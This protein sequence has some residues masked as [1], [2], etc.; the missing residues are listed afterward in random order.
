MCVT[1][2]RRAERLRFDFLWTN[3]PKPKR[4]RSAA[5][6]SSLLR[7]SGCLASRFASESP[8]E[9]R[10]SSFYTMNILRRFFSSLCRRLRL[11]S[12][13]IYLISLMLLFSSLSSC[14]CCVIFSFQFLF[15]KSSCWVVLFRY[16]TK[17]FFS[18]SWEIFLWFLGIDKAKTL[19]SMFQLFSR[20]RNERF[21]LCDGSLEERND[22]HEGGWKEKIK[23]N[24]LVRPSQ[25]LP[26][27]SYFRC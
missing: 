16:S 13:F 9:K 5:Q 21:D 26:N 24:H 19:F 3:H 22:W 25:Y 14:C 10:F 2:L 18:F 12:A 20:V 8:N 11:Y 1:N 6:I 23:K 7:V 17:T 15:K 4:K 27:W